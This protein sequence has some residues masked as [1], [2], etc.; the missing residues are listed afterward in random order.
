MRGACQLRQRA[1]KL[2]HGKRRIFSVLRV[3]R[4]RRRALKPERHPARRA[5]KRAGSG[6]NLAL[7]KARE[8]VRAVNFRNRFFLEQLA[9][10]SRARAGFFRRL[11]QQKHVPAH[12]FSLQQQSHR[13]EARR[14]SVVPAKMRRAAV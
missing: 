6:I 11:E 9:A 13:A 2:P 10:G 1:K 12:G 7:R 14:V 3:G 8:V 4:V 5:G